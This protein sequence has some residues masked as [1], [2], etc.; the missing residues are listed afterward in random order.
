MNE[1]T[2][3]G[4]CHSGAVEY[5]TSLALD[6]LI[7]CNCSICRRQGTILGFTS[8][9]K[10]TLLKGEGNLSDYQFGSRNIHHVFCNTCG[11]KSFGKGVGPDGVEMYAVNVRCL[12][13]V[14][15]DDLPLQKF[16]GASL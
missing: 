10:F 13:G 16:D 3:H 11:V 4:S 5:E 14:D 12:V 9:E 1:H 8:K 2:Y 6:Q 15:I 7:T